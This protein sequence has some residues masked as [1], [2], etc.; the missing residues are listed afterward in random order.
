MTELQE[1]PEELADGAVAA[2]SI[3]PSGIA[4]DFLGVVDGLQDRGVVFGWS[5]GGFLHFHGEFYFL[6]EHSIYWSATEDGSTSPWYYS[7]D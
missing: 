4:F 1:V 7:F 6:G 5:P 3:H 2:D